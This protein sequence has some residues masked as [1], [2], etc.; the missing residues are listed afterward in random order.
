MENFIRRS[1]QVVVEI[2]SECILLFTAD[3][4][5]AGVSTFEKC[6]GSYSSNLHIFSYIV[7]EDILSINENITLIKGDMLCTNCQTC[8]IMPKKNIHYP[9]YIIKFGM[10][11]SGIET[12]GEGTILMVNLVKVGW[13][14][15]KSGY[16]IIP[17]GEL[18][19]ELYHLS[20]NS[21]KEKIGLQ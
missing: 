3:T 14:V 8:L 12:L 10:S 4:F 17:Y 21:A 9:G 5:H 6:N 19:N 13:V 11:P 20:N 15:L 7:E 18:E 2:P 16:S 1:S